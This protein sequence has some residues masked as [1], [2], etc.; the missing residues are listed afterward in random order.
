MKELFENW[1]EIKG[2][3]LEGLEPHKKNV[4][5]RLLEN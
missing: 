2:A 5:D 1:G 3:L 4:V